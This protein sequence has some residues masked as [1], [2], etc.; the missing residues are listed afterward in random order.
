MPRFH[1][2]LEVKD[3]AASVTDYTERL[4]AEPCFVIQDAY[5]LW[6]TEHLN[7]SIVPSQQQQFALRH[8]GW[9]QDEVCDFTAEKTAE[10]DVNGIVWETFDFKSQL[11]AIKKL[12]PDA[13]TQN[14]ERRSISL[15]ARLKQLE[16]LVDRMKT[17]LSIDESLAIYEQ[18]TKLA[19]ACEQALQ[20]SEQRIQIIQDSE[21]TTAPFVLKD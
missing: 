8:L 17:S 9:E 16:K 21:G 13:D 12:W 6:R 3:F 11:D 5:A 1:L 10:K 20:S 4:Q 19:A 2:A 14:L 18:G 15:E 7:V